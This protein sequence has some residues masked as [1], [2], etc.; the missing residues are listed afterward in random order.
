MANMV[1]TVTYDETGPVNIIIVDWLSDDAAG[2]WT[3]DTK[4]ISGSLVKAITDPGA[5][6][7]TDDYDITIKDAAAYNVLTHAHDD[8]VDRDTANVE[9]VYF[10][11]SDGAAIHGNFPV[12]CDV[13]TIAGAACGNAKVGQLR[14][15]WVPE[16]V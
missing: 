6:A 13:L 16:A 5:T 4:K 11:L 3:A 8:L 14:V 2:T 7:P 15:Y 9:E 1:A 10:F 12:V